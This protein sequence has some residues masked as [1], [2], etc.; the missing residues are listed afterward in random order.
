MDYENDIYRKPV[1]DQE[2]AAVDFNNQNIMQLQA[3]PEL[4]QDDPHSMDWGDLMKKAG[5]SVGGGQT[6][7]NGVSRPAFGS[8]NTVQSGGFGKY[9]SS[10]MGMI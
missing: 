7:A 10:I 1:W 8:G 2:T 9:R 3:S 6:Q 4:A 5:S